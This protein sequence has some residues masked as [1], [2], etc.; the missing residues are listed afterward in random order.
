MAEI[1]VTD[2][3]V[4]NGGRVDVLCLIKPLIEGAAPGTVIY[5]PPGRYRVEINDACA[6]LPGLIKVPSGV[7][8]RGDGVTSKIHCVADRPTTDEALLAWLFLLDGVHD[9]QIHDLALTST[10][11]LADAFD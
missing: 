6:M 4:N 10:G 1:D 8:I 11:D 5:F 3:G 9:V 7:T 2:R